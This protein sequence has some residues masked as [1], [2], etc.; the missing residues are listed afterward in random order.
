MMYHTKEAP[1]WTRSWVIPS[2]TKMAAQALH[3]PL[4][5]NSNPAHD[6]DANTGALKVLDKTF[7]ELDMGEQPPA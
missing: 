1:K 7:L 4:S 2:S 3:Q 6:Q 5:M